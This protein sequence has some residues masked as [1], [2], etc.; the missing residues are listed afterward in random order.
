MSSGQLP[1]AGGRLPV[2]SGQSP[3]ASGRLPVAGHRPPT[4]GHWP[5]VAD[6]WPH[7]F[8]A[9]GREQIEVRLPP[10]ASVADALAAVL[11]VPPAAVAAGL[12]VRLDG[13]PVPPAAWATTPA[14]GRV[15]TARVAPRGDDSDPLQ[16]ALM[17]GFAVAAIALPPLVV[18]V[19]GA[20]ALIT[21]GSNTAALIGQG[22]VG[23]VI[24]VT[25]MLI[26]QQLF[27]PD[28]PPPPPAAPD[29]LYSLASGRNV[30]RLWAP[31]MLVLGR[32]RVW[33]DLCAQPHTDFVA[34]GAQ[35]LSQI[36]SLGMGD[37]RI[38]AGSER[39][40][41]TPFDAIEG[42][43]RALYAPGV[44]VTLVDEDVDS[45]Q[46]RS[47]DDPTPDDA[48]E[49][50]TPPAYTWRSS[51]NVRRIEIDLVGQVFRAVAGAGYREHSLAIDVA[52]RP[53]P[54]AGDPKAWDAADF[55]AAQKETIT[56]RADD[57][58]QLRQTHGWNVAPG[59]WDL[60]VQRAARL[61]DD[62]HVRDSVTLGGIR[63]VQASS[64][65]RAGEVRLALR[66]T[67]S[68]GLSGAL[69]RY[70]CVLS[71][72]VPTW[73]D[74]ANSGAG[75]WTAARAASSNPA[76]LLRAFALGSYDDAGA[77]LWGSGRAAADVDDANLGA[78]YAWCEAQDLRCDMVLTAAETTDEIEARIARCGEASIS[79]RSGKFGVVWE[80]PVAVAPAL[81]T[82]GRILAG[83][84]GVSWVAQALADEVV[85]EYAD[86]ARDWTLQEV[87]RT[88]PG[89]RHPVRSARLRPRG[90]THRTQ[91]QRA[92][93]LQAASQLYRRRRLTWE[94]GEDGITL[95]RG[96]VV[97]LTHSLISGGITGRLAGIQPD[98][99]IEMTGNLVA[100]RVNNRDVLRLGEPVAV[101]EPWIDP[102]QAP[103]PDASIWKIIEF[104]GSIILRFGPGRTDLLPAI[105]QAVVI[106]LAAGGDVLTL[107]P[108]QM[109]RGDTSDAYNWGLRADSGYTEWRG[110][111]RA[112][113]A[114]T[115]SL[116][117]AGAVLASAANELLGGI[118]LDRAVSP[119]GTSWIMLDAPGL[120]APHV[121]Q[122]S[123]AV[124]GATVGLLTPLSRPISAVA[125][126]PRDVIW[127]LYDSAAPPATVRIAD[128]VP[129]SLERVRF[130]AYDETAE[131]HAAATVR[132]EDPLPARRSREA[133][134]LSGFLSERLI[135]AGTGYAVEMEVTV[136][137]AG[138]WRGG[139]VQARIGGAAWRTAARIENGETSARWI[140]SAT[141]GILNVRV[142]PGSAAAPV[143]QPFDLHP[144]RIQGGYAA[145]A[146]PT[147]FLVE[148]LGDGTRRFR[149][150]PPADADVIGYELRCGAA[151][152][153]TLEWHEMDPDETGI[154]M[155]HGLLTH[156]FVETTE[157]QTPGRF[158]FIVRARDAFG[159]LSPATARI[160]AELPPSR[161]GDL[162]HWDCPSAT[163]W[164]GSYT[165]FAVAED[166]QMALEGVPNFT[167]ASLEAYSWDQ[168]EAHALGT[169]PASGAAR[170]A[171]YTPPAVDLGAEVSFGLSWA[172]VTSGT[173]AFEARHKGAG[174]SDAWSAWAA[175]AAGDRITARHV[176]VRWRLTGDGSVVLRM[177]HI[178]WS[179]LA[180]VKT[181]R[182]LNV[183]WAS[184]TD[185]VERADWK[186]F[187]PADIV[188]VTDVDVTL[189]NAPAGTT[190]TAAVNPGPGETAK[191]FLRIDPA[192][193]RVSSSLRLNI[194]LRGI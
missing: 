105:E 69:D 28:A 54:S 5:L 15:L 170:A 190:W 96:D 61:S 48:G 41:E 189:M 165:G 157:P 143:G 117:V 188:N 115:A 137:V 63:W 66:S 134:I 83:T 147:N 162:L 25:G 47:L 194:T 2:A 65:V 80:E 122:I 75:A 22:L 167:W 52:W 186:A 21:V 174:E 144:W 119:A 35:R 127:R 88:A 30:A 160:D 107:G 33:P 24:S 125:D 140:E 178:C 161:Q 67:A 180:P 142:I 112:N 102:D 193:A 79:W 169:G 73:D 148:A 14:E 49:S 78:W 120:D 11:P 179:V 27:A 17:I 114:V 44:A 50:W 37:V 100:A 131:W 77:L 175:Y 3:G 91:A 171:S 106:R 150:T 136:T 36:Y 13:A 4:T 183:S 126:S 156:D 176:Q 34:G 159:R 146:A 57:P 55:P 132:A 32:H 71:Q 90:I 45:V 184:L 40:G 111:R 59:V 38:E 86:A 68:A 58:T 152:A 84:F 121:S 124:L 104:G 138:D 62:D 46:G 166:S 181:E 39:M 31:V 141:S 154:R 118:V 192:S 23:G 12:D 187:E 89:T 182:L 101:P 51:A 177:D 191:A 93:N 9:H 29:P 153:G 173:V 8:S 76:A 87:R 158:V 26:S 70:N 7:P 103:N 133:R 98:S 42:I 116:I 155:H 185:A 1:V 113:E 110:R 151:A 85:V 149:W 72:R 92:A 10:G 123:D 163:G 129:L 94:M 168:L 164:P 64:A 139:T 145:P 60:R 16:V 135:R 97:A 19:E 56:L 82:P 6:L 99:S 109:S 108:G 130:E 18:G 128:V 74:A 81:I 53:V 20:G 95:G 43:E 172:G